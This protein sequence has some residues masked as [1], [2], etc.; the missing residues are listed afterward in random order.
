MIKQLLFSVL[1]LG[2]GNYHSPSIETIPAEDYYEQVISAL[3]LLPQNYHPG[4]FDCAAIVAA[5]DP[6]YQT[7]AAMGTELGWLEKSAH[8]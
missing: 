2:Q 4:A 5:D 8:D 3:P 1:A 6:S 7:T